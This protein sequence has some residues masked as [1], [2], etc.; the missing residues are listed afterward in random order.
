MCSLVQMQIGLCNLVGVKSGITEAAKQSCTM[1]KV[2]TKDCA[3]PG[4]ILFLGSVFEKIS[5]EEG[6]THSSIPSQHPL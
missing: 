6:Q 3:P 2:T 4:H 1:G 5:Q